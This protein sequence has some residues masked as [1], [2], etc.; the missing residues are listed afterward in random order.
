MTAKTIL[1]IVIL[2]FA[3]VAN[4]QRNRKCRKCNKIVDPGDFR[5][6]DGCIYTTN[7]CAKKVSL[8]H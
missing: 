3:L 4:A 1:A 7:D 5:G 8:E 2:S 6:K